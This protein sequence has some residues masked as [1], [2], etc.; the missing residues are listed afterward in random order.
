MKKKRSRGIVST[1]YAPSPTGEL[2]VGG[3]RTALFNYL[4]A[5]KHNGRFIL[6]IE[7][8]D[9]SR[10][11][12]DGHIA[13]ENSLK[14][15]SIFPDE[16][17]SNP[18]SFGPYKQ[19]QKLGKYR[20]VCHRLLEE[21]KAY[22]CFCTEEELEA[23]R[24]RALDSGETPKYSRKCMRLSPEQIEEKIKEGKPFSVRL[25]VDIAENYEWDDLIRG[26][27]STP[28]SSMSDYIIMRS[29]DLPTYNFAVVIDDSDMKITCVLRGEE[30]IPNTP[31]QLATYLAL[32]LEDS[33]P[34]FGHLSI[35]VDEN[36]RKLSKRSGDD[37]HFVS[38]LIGKGYLPAAIVNFLVLLG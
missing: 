14:Q 1:R 19:S 10:N 37:A 28:S 24:K 5:K 36:R 23:A 16:S 9:E 13:I 34:D 4:Y 2:H 26:H 15:L 38:R 17:F 3:A 6:R 11:I 12:Q 7:D 29:N 33:I 35:I 8:T 20:E 25:K 32:G 27:I 18:G 30:H 22:R 21:G 31:Y